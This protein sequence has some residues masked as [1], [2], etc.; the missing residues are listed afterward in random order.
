M[1]T[2]AAR[3]L[4]QEKASQTSAKPLP[5]EIVDFSG[6]A[7]DVDLWE[8]QREIARAVTL[9]PRV[10]VKSGHKIG[11]SDVAAAVAL[12][13]VSDPVA[14]PQ[15]RV[16]LTSSSARQV[17][18]ILWKAIRRLY[19]KA[20]KKGYP[21]GG[22]LHKTPDNGLQ[23]DDGREII[24]FSTK[25][26]EKFAGY[27]GKWLLFILD[28]AS[29]IDQPIFDT[30]EGN[31]AG[32][33]RLL[34]LS[35]PT[36]VSGEF[37]EAFNSKSH[38]YHCIHV[39]SRETPNA[40]TGQELIPG[41][42]SLAWCDE[43][44]LEWGEDDERYQVRVLGNFPGQSS[45]AVISLLLAS[46]AMVRDIKPENQEPLVFGL[47]VARFGEDSPMLC[48]RRGLKTYPM[49]DLPKSDGPT[50][51]GHAREKA[52]EFA[53]SLGIEEDALLK[54]NVDC[55]GLGWSCFDALKGYEDIEA[56]A[57]NG[58]EKAQDTNEYFNCRTELYFLARKFLRAGGSIPKDE[59]L[60]RQLVAHDFD[61]SP[62]TGASRVEPKE[63]VKKKIGCS[64]DKADAFVLTFY[65]GPSTSFTRIKKKVKHHGR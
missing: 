38:L 47:D 40:L 64:P 41:L 15:A 2:R 4:N 3:R 61:F 35:N 16:I 30:L 49:I 58:A 31:R 23:F 9:Y 42:A 12:W 60:K 13:W 10:A 21:L 32:G 54:I 20:K 37:Y 51:A 65:E 27:S 28:E 33:A 39:S 36:R 1:K 25:E 52:R 18:S 26:P 50:L 17:K 43:K 5:A 46:N 11:K 7:L 22:V 57:V 48:A 56:V 53:T 6:E 44:L 29:G 63:K 34:C 45:S 14:R 19:N 55:V 24:G 59:D 62:S 8:R